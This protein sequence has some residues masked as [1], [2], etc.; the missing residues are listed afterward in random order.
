[1]STVAAR[2]LDG[3]EESGPG[4]VAHPS[5]CPSWCKDYGSP[6]RHHFGPSSTAHW[7]RQ[8]VLPGE[9][10]ELLARAELVRLDGADRLG[11]TVLHLSGE[12]E[13]EVEELVDVDVLIAQGEAWVAGL[14]VLRAWMA[15][16]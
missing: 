4:P 7:S 2:P 1:M 8:V 3:A 5:P 6:M 10:G 11:E 15:A 13:V 14:R 9:G 12:S 16:G